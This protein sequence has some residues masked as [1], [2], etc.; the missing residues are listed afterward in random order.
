MT[1]FKDDTVLLGVHPRLDSDTDDGSWNSRTEKAQRK[2]DEMTTPKFSDPKDMYRMIADHAAKSGRNDIVRRMNEKIKL[3]EDNF[4]H[5]FEALK[6]FEIEQKEKQLSPDA[7]RILDAWKE[8]RNIGHQRWEYT[9]VEAD[10]DDGYDMEE[11]KRLGSDGWELVA[12]LQCCAY[13]KRPL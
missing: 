7:R 4:V 2:A 10:D 11:F 6:D 5:S 8:I 9:E 1:D 12:I 3:L 13:F